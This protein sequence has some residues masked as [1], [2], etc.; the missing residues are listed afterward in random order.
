MKYVLYLDGQVRSEWVENF[1]TLLDDTKVFSLPNGTR[2]KQSEGNFRMIIE[3]PDLLMA[4]PATITRCSIIYTSSNIISLKMFI[5]Q[6]LS[7]TKFPP[8]LVQELEQLFLKLTKEEV[9]S[10]MYMLPSL[11]P[12]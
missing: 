6:Q 4:S 5:D 11:M 8:D 10:V 2:L 7:K 12:K 1:N 9:R 3:T